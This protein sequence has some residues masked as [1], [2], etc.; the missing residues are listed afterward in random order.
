MQ[1]ELKTTGFVKTSY[2][3]KYF[4]NFKSLNIM[5]LWNVSLQTHFTATHNNLIIKSNSLSWAIISF[6]LWKEICLHQHKNVRYVIL[7]AE[8]CIDANEEC[9]KPLIS[10]VPTAL[11]Q[12]QQQE[13]QLTRIIATKT[14]FKIMNA[15]IPALASNRVVNSWTG[16]RKDI[17]CNISRCSMYIHPNSGTLTHNIYKRVHYVL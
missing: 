3:F 12:Q 6:Q 15:K 17:A 14:H 13:Q 16:L 1:V 10:N 8:M 4:T 7:A 2:D 11:Q 9:Y 5:E